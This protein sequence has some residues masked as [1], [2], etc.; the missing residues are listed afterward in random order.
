MK[1][2]AASLGG[3]IAGRV[4]DNWQQLPLNGNH[5][6]RNL[7]SVTGQRQVTG[8]SECVLRGIHIKLIHIQQFLRNLCC[9]GEC[10]DCVRLQAVGKPNTQDC[11]FLDTHRF[12]H[13]ASPTLG[14]NGE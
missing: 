13:V 8:Q 9:N 12:R 14:R 2:H 1:A 6:Q 10:L 7:A 11:A 4:E 5:L 3:L